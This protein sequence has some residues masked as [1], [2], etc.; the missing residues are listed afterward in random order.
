MSNSSTLS[1]HDITNFTIWDTTNILEYTASCFAMIWIACDRSH[2]PQTPA[3]KACFSSSHDWWKDQFD[4]LGFPLPFLDVNEVMDMV[5]DHFEQLPMGAMLLLGPV[6][7]GQ[8]K[9][10][11][12]LNQILVVMACMKHLGKSLTSLLEEKI[13]MAAEAAKT[14]SQ[15]EGP[16]ALHKCAD[17]RGEKHEEVMLQKFPHGPE[18][19]LEKPSVILDSASHI[20]VWYLPDTISLWI[21]TK[22]A[23]ATIGM[24]S[25]LKNSM[26]SGPDTQW[27]TF[28]GNFYNSNGQK[29]TPGCINLAPCWF[30]QG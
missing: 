13:R 7:T 2:V 5:Q 27:R 11:P 21:Q 25:L 4:T 20:I 9:G 14:M 28:T 18:C 24:G 1:T 30:Q 23:D 26:T 17:G 12:L 19:L 15:L 29:L 8:V 10:N 22:M 16:M 3:Y 6:V